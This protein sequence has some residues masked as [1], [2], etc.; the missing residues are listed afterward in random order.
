MTGLSLLAFIRI[1][2]RDQFTEPYAFSKFMRHDHAVEGNKVGKEIINFKKDG[3]ST[4][5]HDAGDAGSDGG[6]E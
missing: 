1:R 6:G 2:F 4:A 3:S 5:E